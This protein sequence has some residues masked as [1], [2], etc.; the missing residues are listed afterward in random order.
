MDLN[1]DQGRGSERGFK[2]SG[3]LGLRRAAV[4]EENAVASC[5]DK[6]PRLAPVQQ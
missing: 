6:Q 5:I 2:I 3:L 1:R 4:V